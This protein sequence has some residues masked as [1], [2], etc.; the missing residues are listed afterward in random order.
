MSFDNSVVIF[1]GGATITRDVNLT[2]E[3]SYLRV[4]VTPTSDRRGLSSVKIV[5]SNSTPNN[6]KITDGV[7]DD[8]LFRAI[9]FSMK[10][11]G[12]MV[13]RVLDHLGTLPDEEIAVV[14]KEYQKYGTTVANGFATGLAAYLTFFLLQENTAF[15]GQLP[16]QFSLPATVFSANIVNANTFHHLSLPLTALANTVKGVLHQLVTFVQTFVNIWASA[17]LPGP[18]LSATLEARLCMEVISGVSHHNSKMLVL[19][20]ENAAEK[21]LSETR[22][23]V[24]AHVD[25]LSNTQTQNHNEL[26]TYVDNALQ[27]MRNDFNASLAEASAKAY[28]EAYAKASAES[29]KAFEELSNS[30]NAVALTTKRR[31]ARSRIEPVV[32]ERTWR[33]SQRRRFDD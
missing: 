16:F 24:S 7:D 10:G 32:V 19:A 17:F 29:K 13:D 22:A 15:H 18:D 5:F 12:A 14:E 3:P 4:Q 11:E 30:V 31:P 26:K 33:Q 2:S 6:T 25:S 1:T 27:K 28:T 9:T 20:H 23:K 8:T 21:V